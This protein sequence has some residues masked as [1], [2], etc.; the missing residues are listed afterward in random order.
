MHF[1]LGSILGTVAMLLLACNTGQAQWAGSS[2][3]SSDNFFHSLGFQHPAERQ[4]DYQWM[5]MQEQVTS[6]VPIGATVQHFEG[7]LTTNTSIGVVIS[8]SPGAV[9]TN[10]G[11]VDAQ[12]NTG[13]R[14]GTANGF[15]WQKQ[16]SVTVQAPAPQPCDRGCQ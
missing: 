5:I 2:V 9:G 12:A 14:S 3:A 8:N 4:A 10:T 16:G 11:P 7:G 15:I 13:S 1:T 6:G